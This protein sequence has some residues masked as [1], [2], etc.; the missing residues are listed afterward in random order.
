MIGTSLE[1]STY[2]NTMAAKVEATM[3]ISTGRGRYWPHVYGR[4]L[5]PSDG[6]TMRKR[7]SHMPM[8]TV[9]D[10][11][12]QPVI[13]RSFL[14]ERM[15]NGIAKLQ[16]TIVQKSGANE[17]RCVTSDTSRSVDALPYPKV[18]RSLKMK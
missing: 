14:I 18:S 4:Y 7:S 10:A 11:M 16:A 1:N 5:W 15:T 13:V 3:M 2:N 17:P 12:T 8:T 9:N 6:T